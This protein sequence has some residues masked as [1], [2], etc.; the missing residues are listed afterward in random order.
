MYRPHA[1]CGPPAYKPCCPPVSPSRTS[2]F[3]HHFPPPWV[4]ISSLTPSDNEHK[5][6]SVTLSTSHSSPA[7]RLAPQLSAV[8]PPRLLAQRRSF[9]VAPWPP[10]LSPP[11]QLRLSW[12][13]LYFPGVPQRLCPYPSCFFCFSPLSILPKPTMLTFFFRGRGTLSGRPIDDQ[14][15]HGYKVAQAEAAFQGPVP[16]E[17]YQ[18]MSPSNR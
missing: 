2:S 11:P 5:W 17:I 8:C 1:A 4:P 13:F 16:L 3:F 10:P 6:S 18:Q 15:Q 7:H 14:S 12:P 9:K